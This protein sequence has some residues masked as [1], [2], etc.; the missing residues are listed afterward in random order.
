MGLDP[1]RMRRAYGTDGL[2][3]AWPAVRKKLIAEVERARAQ[4]D[5]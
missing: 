1:D 3:A 2:P 4:L 5:A